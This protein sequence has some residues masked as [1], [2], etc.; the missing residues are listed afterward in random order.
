MQE[1]YE[2]AWS[3]VNFVPS[4]FVPEMR[5][6]VRRVA[7]EEAAELLSDMAIEE[8]WWMLMLRGLV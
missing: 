6:R 8:A 2:I 5:R 1:M 7:G 3:Y 4:H